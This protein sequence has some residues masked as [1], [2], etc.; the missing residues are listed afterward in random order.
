MY[1]P[2]NKAFAIRIKFNKNKNH[3]NRKVGFG[4]V[5]GIMSFK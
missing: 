3:E 4:Y 2:K 1:I 5:N